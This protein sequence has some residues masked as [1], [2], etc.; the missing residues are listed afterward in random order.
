MFERY[1]E[2][3]RRVI[4]FARF[5]A[6]NYG[7]TR[8]E[9]EHVLLGLTREDPVLLRRF[10]GT[11]GSTE[12]I[13]EELDKQLP[14]GE[15]IS[16]S[17]EMPLTEEC[18]KVLN[19]AVEECDRMAHKYCDTGHL[20]LGVLRAERSLAARIL[21]QRGAKTEAIREI[22]ANEPRANETKGRF[23]PIQPGRTTVDNFLVGLGQAR[24]E[25]IAPFFSASAQFVDWAGKRFVG[26]DEI[27]KEFQA[28]FAP[29][30][31]KNVTFVLEQAEPAPGQSFIAS[32]LWENVSAGGEAARVMHRMTMA[33]AVEDGD[34]AIFLL[35]VTPVPVR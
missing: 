14:R 22:L 24:W 35:Q 11:N 28:L 2:K 9:T 3:A 30:A 17:V 4:F 10:L 23:G 31:K 7:S 20:L 15:R 25:Q 12:G 21:R 19:F 26:R 27:E 32:V 1:T 5:E 18:K 34:W 33:L 29:Y 8:I 13:R 6:S 16:T